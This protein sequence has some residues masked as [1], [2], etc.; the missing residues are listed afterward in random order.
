MPSRKTV[1]NTRVTYRRRRGRVTVRSKTR[2]RVGRGKFM[3]FLKKASKF[4]KKTKLLSKLGKAYGSTSAP[5]SKHIGKA[6]G[7][8]DQLGYGRRRKR[9]GGSLRPAGM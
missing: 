8:A 4:L 1:T 6:A 7:F 5:F 3:N 9:C 2:H